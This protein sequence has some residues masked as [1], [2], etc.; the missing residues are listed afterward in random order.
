MRDDRYM[1][2]RCREDNRNRDKATFGKD[3]VRSDLLQI[4]ARLEHTLYDPERIRKIFQIKVSPELSGGN[5]VIWNTAVLDQLLLHAALGADIIDF[6]S[7][8]FQRRYKRNIR[9]HMTG[10]SAA[11]KHNLLHSFSNLSHVYS[12]PYPHGTELPY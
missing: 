1:K 4:P 2:A 6:I 10:C 5:P 9:C 7:V 12:F 8:F 3:N 11:G